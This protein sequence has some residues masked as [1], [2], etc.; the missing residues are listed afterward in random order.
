MRQP[1][2]RSINEAVRDFIE[3]RSSEVEADLQE[4]LRRLQA[5]RVA[6][7]DFESAIGRFVDAE[8]ASVRDETAARE[9]PPVH[10]PRRK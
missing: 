5:Y 1:V 6:D 8:A 10:S 7:P 2:N 3:R 4:S 9:T